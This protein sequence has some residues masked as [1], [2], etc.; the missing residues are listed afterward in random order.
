MPKGPICL[1]RIYATVDPLTV[2]R[3]K[4]KRQGVSGT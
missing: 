4:L 3:R 2:T 1:L